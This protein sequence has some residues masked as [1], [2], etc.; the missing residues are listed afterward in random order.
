MCM[1]SYMYEGFYSLSS[2]SISPVLRS[3]IWPAYYGINMALHALCME[4]AVHIRVGR[5]KL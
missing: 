5:K 3:T 2:R 4:G 1:H